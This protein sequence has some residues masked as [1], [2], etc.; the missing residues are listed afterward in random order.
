MASSLC[1]L[2]TADARPQWGQVLLQLF[3][4]A[5]LFLSVYSVCRL[6][7]KVWTSSAIQINFTK[8]TH[9]DDSFVFLLMKLAAKHYRHWRANKKML[10]QCIIAFFKDRCFFGAFT[11]TLSWTVVGSEWPLLPL[12][13]NKWSD[14]NKCD[15]FAAVAECRVSDLPELLALLST[16]EK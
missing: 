5:V 11:N 6:N 4:S 12:W 8:E 9:I 3:S 2:L 15:S 16:V 14:S 7:K 10:S 13:M 1:V